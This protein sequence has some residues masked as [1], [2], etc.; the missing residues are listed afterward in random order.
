MGEDQVY[1]GFSGTITLCEG[2]R[3][4]ET[5]CQGYADF[6]N[7]RPNGPDTAF[8]MASGSK[9]FTAVAALR[10]VERSLLGLDEPVNPRIAPWAVHEAASLRH[11]LTHTSGIADYF[12]E[13]A[14]ED[15]E[16]LWRE[17]PN[18]RMRSP[19]DFLPLFAGRPGSFAPGERFRYSDS[20]F[21]LAAYLVERASGRAFPDYLRETVFEPCGM[22]RTGCFRLDM[23]PPDAATGYIEEGGSLRSNLYSIPLVGGGDGG[24]LTTGADMARFWTA[25]EEGRL[26]KPDTVESM[27]SVQVPRTDEDDRY[28]L[29]VWILEDDDEVAFVQGFDPG[30][31]FLSYFD[32]R[33]G[34]SLTISANVECRLGPLVRAWLPR[35]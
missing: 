6:P 35:L 20:G 3:V 21:V 30:V 4:L 19:E 25:L 28:G 11:L 9:I 23:P 18:Y 32:R 14:G 12:D 16:A 34:R 15:Y 17:R 10:L 2:E 8:G 31:R 22:G 7:Q 5:F 29:G 1:E 26:L 13:E 24:C 27:L 33:S